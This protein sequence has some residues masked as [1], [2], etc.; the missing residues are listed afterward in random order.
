MP[1]WRA[2]GAHPILIAMRTLARTAL[3][4]AFAA[5]PASAQVEPVPESSP[6][7][8]DLK[9]DFEVIVQVLSERAS[10]SPKPVF[11]KGAR[12]VGFDCARRKPLP[13]HGGSPAV[14]MQCERPDGKSDLYIALAEDGIQQILGRCTKADGTDVED[15]DALAAVLSHEMT[16]AATDM[17]AFETQTAV[18]ACKAWSESFA[19]RPDAE[20]TMMKLERWALKFDEAD[21]PSKKKEL[22]M[23]ECFKDEESCRIYSSKWIELEGQMDGGG[24]NLIGQ[25]NKRTDI[26]DELRFDPDGMECVFRR[27]H[28]IHSILGSP[29]N[30]C[31][32]H[33]SPKERAEAAKSFAAWLAARLPADGAPGASEPR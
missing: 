13:N 14:T 7:S 21:R 2:A 16:H 8:R 32:Q 6:Y 29:R 27:V 5:G 25:H 11:V 19:Q 33:A 1:G 31:P 3:L 18:E 30:P 17:I 20:E 12:S 9:T 26:T 22:L 24:Q 15:F 23:A 28:E 10:V 4:C